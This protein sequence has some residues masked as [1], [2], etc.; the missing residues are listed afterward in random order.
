MPLTIACTC[1][2]H[3]SVDEQYAGQ[4]V[5]CSVCQ[6][7][8]QIPLSPTP[9]PPRQL[10]V[11]CVCGQH[12]SVDEQYAGQQVPCSVCQRPIQIPVPAVTA[13]FTNQASAPTQYDADLVEP[14]PAPRRGSAGATAALLV[15]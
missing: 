1:G 3:Y 14:P 6:R 7:P 2:Q 10:T 5:P 9:A 11:A 15:T 4:Q 13:V 8:I 12:Y